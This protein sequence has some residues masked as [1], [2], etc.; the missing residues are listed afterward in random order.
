M[1]S[2]VK[3]KRQLIKTFKELN[4]IKKRVTGI[5]VSRIAAKRLLNTALQIRKEH[6]RT[7]IKTTRT[8]QSMQICDTKDFGEGCHMASTDL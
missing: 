1:C 8:I 6:A 2:D 5:A 3:S 4:G 7:L